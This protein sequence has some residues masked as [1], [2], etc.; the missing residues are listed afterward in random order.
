M[1]DSRVDAL[2]VG[3]PVRFRAD[4]ETSSIGA[5]KTTGEPT[6]LT[7][8]GFEGDQVADQSVHGGPDKAVHF[9][10][11]EHYPVWRAHF[12]MKGIKAHSLLETSGGFGENISGVG[13]TE[14]NVRIGDRFRVGKALV[15]I[16]QGR[17]PC[18]KI[19]HHF[20]IQGMTAAVIS[21]GRCG[22]YFRVI[23]QGIVTAGDPLVQ[24]EQA[25][26]S[27]SVARSFRLLIGGGHKAVDA[28]QG[29]KE[30]A[31]METLAQSWRERAFRLLA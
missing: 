31:A 1:I 3:K 25:T 11:A 28:Q 7:Y 5:R 27:W 30:L 12:E 4:G 29:L 23:E 10:P 24:V 21:T 2:Y 9:Y 16:A 20:G 6:Y 15:E 18:W 22:L 8:L 26:H 17:Q 14:G 19:D 13:L